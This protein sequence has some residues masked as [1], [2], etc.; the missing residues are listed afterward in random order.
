MAVSGRA[1]SG[2]LQLD[3]RANGLAYSS[4]ASAPVPDSSSGWV[5]LASVMTAWPSRAGLHDRPFQ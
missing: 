4:L 2:A 1:G 5:R 3:G